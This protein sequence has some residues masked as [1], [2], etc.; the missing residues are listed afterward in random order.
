MFVSPAQTLNETMRRSE[1]VKTNAQYRKFVQDNFSSIRN[2]N[3]STA[4]LQ[5]ATRSA[6][7]NAVLTEVSDLKDTF[8]QR[9]F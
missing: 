9:N 8:M 3:A 2:Y 5:V 1:G 4:A 6:P 7:N